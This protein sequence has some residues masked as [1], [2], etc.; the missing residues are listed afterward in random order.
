MGTNSLFLKSVSVSVKHVSKTFHSGGIKT[1]SD[2][3]F[4]K[5]VYTNFAII[6]LELIN[7]LYNALS[8]LLIFVTRNIC[9]RSI[10]VTSFS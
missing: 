8:E 4:I 9:R 6:N 7:N 3:N 10:I 1:K 2:F 5:K